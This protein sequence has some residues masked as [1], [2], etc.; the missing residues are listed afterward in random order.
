MN[1]AAEFLSYIH[2]WYLVDYINAAMDEGGAYLVST[3]LGNVA[4]VRRRISQT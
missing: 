1:F 4:K 3:A 2:V